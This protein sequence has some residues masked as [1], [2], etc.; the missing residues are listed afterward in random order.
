[1]PQTSVSVIIPA[2]NE[3]KT[4]GNVI[5]ETISIM[6]GQL[7][8]YEVIVVNDGSTDQTGQVASKHKARVLSN[9]K[10]RGKGYSI[11]KALEQAQG[12]III[13]IDSDGEHNPKEIP[14]LLD[15]VLGGIDVVS[16]SRFMSENKYA[17]TKLNR[18]GNFVFNT[19]ILALTGNYITD[20]QSGFRAMRRKVLEEISLK[21][22]GYEIET[23][24]TVKGL[25][26]GFI[27]R[28]RPI[29]CKRRLFNVSKVK[30]VRD[31]TKILK[32]ILLES[33]AKP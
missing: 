13:T 11:R 17:T 14:D 21:S 20:S 2:Y 25:K 15:P 5:K 10:N 16:G 26:N 23:E 3:E 4:I 33:L 28:E 30:L 19:A 29:T 24:I 1:M 9:E 18:I 27:F 8:P 7:M 32:T 22:D 12:D 6:D 31:G